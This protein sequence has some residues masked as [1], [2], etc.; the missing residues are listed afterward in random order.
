MGKELVE[1][2]DKGVQ[3]R[4]VENQHESN[5]RHLTKLSRPVV[6]S[7]SVAER[8]EN[9]QRENLQRRREEIEPVKVQQRAS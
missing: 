7:S 9:R 3:R 1:K 2:S 6:E 8:R 5:G 4:Q